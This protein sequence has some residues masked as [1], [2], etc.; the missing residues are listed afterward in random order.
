M[1]CCKISRLSV[2]QAWMWA[3]SCQS[4]SSGA[5]HFP[6][7]YFKTGQFPGNRAIIQPLAGIASYA[8]CAYIKY[9]TNYVHPLA[10]DIRPR[11][12]R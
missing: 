3:T 5:L 6:L 12:V 4:A 7:P 11:P 10:R 8:L 9:L 1:I 2:G